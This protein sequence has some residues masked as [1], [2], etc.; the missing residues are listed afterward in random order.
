MIIQ[1]QDD[2]GGVRRMIGNKKIPNTPE[3][4]GPKPPSKRG[5]SKQVRRAE[6]LAIQHDNPQGKKGVHV[7]KTSPGA[8]GEVGNEQLHGW[9][10]RQSTNGALIKG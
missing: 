4:V 1:K 7:R 5:A 9:K 6:K 3:A 8:L 10:G 2:P